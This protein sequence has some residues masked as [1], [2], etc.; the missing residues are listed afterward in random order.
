MLACAGAVAALAFPAAAAAGTR[1]FHGA[2]GATGT[3]DLRAKIK[4]GKPVK[5]RGSSRRPGFTWEGIPI[6]CET[7]SLPGDEVSGHF[8]FSI[9]VRHRRFHARGSDGY[10]T[11]KVRGKFRRGDRKARGILRLRGDFPSYDASG[12][13]TG[14]V[15]WRAHRIRT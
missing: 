1:A 3:V 7:G 13:D 5:V 12:C 15:R 8:R 9:R 11:A 2:A 6:E 4:E 10:T 14:K